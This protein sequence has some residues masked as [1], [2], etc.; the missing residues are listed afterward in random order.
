MLQEPNDAQAGSA[1]ETDAGETDAAETDVSPTADLGARP[2]ERGSDQR[3]LESKQ[4]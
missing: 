1:R 4:G 2:S 3:T